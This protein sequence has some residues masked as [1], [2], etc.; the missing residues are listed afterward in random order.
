MKLIAT[1]HAHNL[2]DLIAEILDKSTNNYP[3]LKINQ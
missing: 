3:F 1:F 2:T